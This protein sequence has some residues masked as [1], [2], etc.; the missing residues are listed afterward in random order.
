[1]DAA[2]R[3]KT[4]SIESFTFAGHAEAVNL[5][6]V[7]LPRHGERL[8]AERETSRGI[9]GEID[10]SRLSRN[11]RNAQVDC[12]RNRCGAVHDQ[13]LLRGE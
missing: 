13:L 9:P 11:S 12:A 4:G 7:G 6:A 5:N 1:M 8:E 2:L 3:G 10:R